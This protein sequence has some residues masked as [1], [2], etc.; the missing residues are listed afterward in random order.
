MP[1][2]TKAERIRVRGDAFAS[3]ADTQVIYCGDNL[4]KLRA[5]PAGLVD[6]IYIDPPFNSNRNYEVFWGETKEKRAFEDRHESTKAYIEFMRPRCVELHRVL[7]DTGSFYY[8]CDWHASHYVKVMLD[9]VFGEN[10]F[11]NEIIWKRFS[12]KNDAVRYGRGH[13]AIFFYAKSKQYTWNPQYGPFEEGYVEENYRYTEEGTGRRYRL[14]DLTA[15]KA[16]GDVDYAWHGMKPY[17]GR[18]WAY[19]REKMDQFLAEGRIVFRRTGMPVYKRYLD[20][21]PGVPLQ[22][23][24]TD[25]R[26]QAGS[27]ERVGYPTQK[28]LPLLERIIKSSSDPDEIVLDAFCGC[29]TALVAAQKLERRWIGGVLMLLKAWHPDPFVH[30]PDVIGQGRRHRR[31][32][33][34]P[35]SLSYRLPQRP[36]RPAEVIAVDREVGGYPGSGFGSRIPEVAKTCIIAQPTIPP[37]RK[38]YTTDLT[39]TQWEILRPLIPDAK[40]GGRPRE[41][42]I[43]EVLNTLLYQDRTGCQWE[44]LPH[45]LLPKSTVWDYFKTWRDDGTWQKLVDALREKV[46]RKAG[47]EGTPSKAVIDSQSVKTTEVGGEERGY[48]GGKL[49]SGRKRHVAVDMMGLLL[50]VAVTAA[51]ADDG[52]AASEVL[53]QLDDAKKFPRLKV[54]YADQKYENQTAREWLA[55][56]GDP[57]R[58][59]IVRRP[60]GQEGF[61][62]LPKRWV[63]ERS[64]AWLGRDRRHSKDYERTPQS[65]E[66]WV[67]ISSIRGMLRRLAPDKERPA[68][69]FKYPQTKA[70]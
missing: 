70:A 4:E 55:A 57:F 11:Q 32:P 66:A 19:S 61:V 59:E 58:L 27:R 22:D 50:G 2:R 35:A 10:N 15:N 45:D 48:D 23:V 30:R 39:D 9:Q 18:H 36:D 21:M 54:V 17:K 14:S 56:R 52:N 65:G 8:H 6:L 5:M 51:S 64:L 3:H 67:R 60:E 40:P 63:V 31:R 38:P 46:R 25:I 7:K 29:G 28:P 69:P 20:E 44:M 68:A 33:L 41:V 53:W 16:G 34:S 26:L 42:D 43:R 37:M 24:W 49:V 13:D 62:K 1:K 12:A 47:R